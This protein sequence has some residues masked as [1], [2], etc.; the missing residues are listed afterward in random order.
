MFCPQTFFRKSKS[1]QRGRLN[2]TIIHRRIGFFCSPSYDQL[3]F[4][5][6]NL[7]DSGDI[8]ETVFV[9]FSFPKVDNTYCRA[10]AAM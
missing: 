7:Y 5:W 10:V 6:L 1:L 3:N 2:A 4:Q 8:I 9:R